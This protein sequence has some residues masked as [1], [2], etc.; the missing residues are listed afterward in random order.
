MINNI[1]VFS[2]GG[3]MP[4]SGEMLSSFHRQQ[5]EGATSAAGQHGKVLT[6]IL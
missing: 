1:I 6:I 5:L 2:A 3:K 4:T